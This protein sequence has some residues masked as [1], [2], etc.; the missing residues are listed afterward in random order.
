MICEQFS[1]PKVVGEIDGSMLAQV[2]EQF[3]EQDTGTDWYRNG[4]RP[5]NPDLF[6]ALQPFVSTLLE[7]EVSI[8]GRDPYAIFMAVDTR[9]VKA[10]NTQRGHDWHRD[11]GKPG[12]HCITVATALPTEFLV[13]DVGLFGQYEQY[14]KFGRIRHRPFS[15]NQPSDRELQENGLSVYRP[16][17]LQLVSFAREIHRS[18]MNRTG[19]TVARTWIRATIIRRSAQVG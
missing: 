10:G 4:H 6:E 18:P 3:P 11:T 14:R 19:K 9:T 15:G 13:S 5:Y 17:P 8:F 7:K 16:E 12:I 2:A 1:H